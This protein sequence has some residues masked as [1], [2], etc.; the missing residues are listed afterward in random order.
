MRRGKERR[1]KREEDREGKI[2]RV[3]VAKVSTCSGG[4]RWLQ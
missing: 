2:E 3:V 1:G 4:W